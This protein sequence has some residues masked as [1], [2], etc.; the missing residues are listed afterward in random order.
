MSVNVQVGDVILVKLKVD[1]VD[2]KGGAYC[3]S[4]R[5]I[6]LNYVDRDDILEVLPR[7]FKVG[8]K[9]KSS[10]SGII[11]NIV[12]DVGDY[13]VVQNKSNPPWCKGKNAMKDWAR[14]D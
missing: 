5:S 14:V 7:P 6:G 12:G 9:L 4:D 11:F 2:R 8:D 13:Y 10:S 3:Y 1:S